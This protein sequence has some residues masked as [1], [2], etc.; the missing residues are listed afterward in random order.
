[1][2]INHIQ[3][4]EY[5]IRPSLKPLNLWEENSEELII[6]TCAHETLGGT[7]LHELR[8]PACGIY[9]EEPATYKWVWDKIFSDFDKNCDPRNKLSDRILKSIG[10]PLATIP[11]IELII[12]NLYYATIMC[13]LRYACVKE[14]IPDSKDIKGL[15]QY[16][17]M[18][19]NSSK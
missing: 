17:K 14:P 3:L 18:F 12:G 11:E 1:M 9:E 8:G 19:Y 7:F 15:A 2:M 10:R 6:M 16:Y 4:R 13:R 5:I